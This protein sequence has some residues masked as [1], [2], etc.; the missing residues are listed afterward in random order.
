[1][2]RMNRMNQSFRGVVS[3]SRSLPYVLSPSSSQTKTWNKYPTEYKYPRAGLETV[4]VLRHNIVYN[5][6]LGVL[7]F[8]SILQ[9]QYSGKQRFHIYLLY[10]TVYTASLIFVRKNCRYFFLAR[11]EQFN[12]K[13]RQEQDTIEKGKVPPPH[14]HAAVVSLMTN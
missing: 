6:A 13:R 4:N 3:L 9:V 2:N 8:S 11:E 14:H 7:Q 10:N 12:R 1:M 5:I